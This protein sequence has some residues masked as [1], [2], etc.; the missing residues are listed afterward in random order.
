VSEENL[1]RRMS[2]PMVKEIKWHWRKLHH[3][4]LWPCSATNVGRG[5]H[6]KW[7]SKIKL[8]IIIIELYINKEEIEK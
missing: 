7:K 8:K 4:H 6:V 5:R 1:V 2:A 3:E